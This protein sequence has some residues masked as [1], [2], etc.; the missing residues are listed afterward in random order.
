M[1]AN[2]HELRL[3]FL[4]PLLPNGGIGSGTPNFSH[5]WSRGQIYQTNDISVTS[6]SGTFINRCIFSNRN[7]SPTRREIFSEN[8]ILKRRVTRTADAFTLVEILVAMVLMSF[9]VL[10]LMAVFNSTQTAFRARLTQTDVLESGRATMDL[11]TEDLKEM[12]PSVDYS[13]NLVS[14]CVR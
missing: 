5:T 3:T 10:A 4:W 2:L 9:I 11:I 7:R 8:L 6:Y 13:N 1:T 14:V 12:T